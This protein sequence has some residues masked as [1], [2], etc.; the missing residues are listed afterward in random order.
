MKKK[1]IALS[2]LSLSPLLVGC[3]SQQTQAIQTL[4]SQL[5]RVENIIGNGSVSNLS[6]ISSNGNFDMNTSQS[7]LQKQKHI[8]YENM[9]KEDS[10][11]N[12]ILSISACIK[13][14]TKKEY[15]LSKNQ[16]ALIKQLSNNIARYTTSF[17]STTTYTQTNANKILKSQ[18]SNKELN[19]AETEGNY[20]SLSNNMNERYAYMSNIYSNLEK[21]YNLLDCNS[22]CDC[23]TT[24]NTTSCENCEKSPDIDDNNIKNTDENSMKNIDTFANS[25]KEN[26]TAQNNMIPQNNINHQNYC[27]NCP[28]NNFYAPPYYNNSQ[29]NPNRNTDSF[30]PRLRNIDSYRQPITY[31]GYAPYQNGYYNYPAI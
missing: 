29:F 25:A 10:L 12:D 5:T 11:R 23:D 21:I 30:Y 22:Q 2:L 3:S 9:L 1:I 17:D 13:K 4:E 16:A 15:K 24:N 6:Q 26:K 8:S 27:P 28:P 20:L 14:C 19:L 18:G 7:S 31:N